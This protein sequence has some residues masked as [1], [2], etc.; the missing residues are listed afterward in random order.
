VN[1]L[2]GDAEL[3]NLPTTYTIGTSVHVRSLVAG[4][5]SYD[6]AE[7]RVGGIVRA[8]ALVDEVS[9]GY[10]FGE[11]RATRG[12]V[13]LPSFAQ[14]ATALRANGLTGAPSLSW[15]WTDDNPVPPF[16]P[17]LTGTDTTGRNAFVTPSGI[18]HQLPVVN[19]VVPAGN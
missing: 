12:D 5:P 11:L 16:A 6:L 1:R 17:F 9:N 13:R 19:G 10:L 18:L 7:L 3:G 8:I 14:M 15:T 2:L 4:V